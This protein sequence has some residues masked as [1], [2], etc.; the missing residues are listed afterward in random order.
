MLVKLKHP[1]AA[2]I[3]L[4]ATSNA[5]HFTFIRDK[6][7]TELGNDEVIEQDHFLTCELL[8]VV[9]MNI[10]GTPFEIMHQF[11]GAVA[12]LENESVVEQLLKLQENIH[13]RIVRNPAA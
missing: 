5:E 11:A 3:V 4:V 1:V 2:H 7:P 8:H 13:I 6:C 12:L 9:E 10:L